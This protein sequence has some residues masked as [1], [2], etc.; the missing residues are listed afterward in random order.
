[1][2]RNCPLCPTQYSPHKTGGCTPKI[3]RV[4]VEI[5]GFFFQAAFDNQQGLRRHGSVIFAMDGNTCKKE[6]LCFEGLV[7]TSSVYCP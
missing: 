3:R 6:V 5:S 1:M 2:F 7:R 4:E